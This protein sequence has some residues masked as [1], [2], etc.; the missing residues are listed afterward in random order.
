[1]PGRG[2]S[3]SPPLAN[4]LGAPAPRRGPTPRARPTDGGDVIPFD[5]LLRSPCAV[6]H[7]SGGLLQPRCHRSPFASGGPEEHASHVPPSRPGPHEACAAAAPSRCL[8]RAERRG[9]G[10]GRRG[11]RRDGRTC[12]S[13][14]P[15][16]TCWPSSPPRDRR[17]GGHR[18]GAPTPRP[19]RR[20]DDDPRP[21]SISTTLPGRGHDVPHRA[22]SASPKFVGR[23][24]NVRACHGLCGPW[25]R[26]HREHGPPSRPPRSPGAINAAGY[27]VGR[28]P[29]LVRDPDDLVDRRCRSRP[30]RRPRGRR[31]RSPG[32]RDSPR[33][34][35]TSPRAASS[36]RCSSG[37]PPA[38]RP[39]WRS[40][41]A[42]SSRS[43]RRSRRAG[44]PRGSRTRCR[45]RC[46]RRSSSS[47]GRIVGYVRLRRRSSARSAPA[48][49]CRR[50]SPRC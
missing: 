47:A 40:S 19:R 8:Q 36:S 29:W 27:E 7:G 44:R 23:L 6:L 42:S 2:P 17:A 10:E 45:R 31:R 21:A 20:R 13:A 5:Q 32:S 35:V 4:P 38:C 48:S 39:A 50:S 25:A 41:A 43:P 18:P 12:P 49:R 14:W 1:M 15:S 11:R 3:P 37:S 16:T 33:A 46:A 9:G 30:R 22:R 28:T 34:P 26:R 24:P